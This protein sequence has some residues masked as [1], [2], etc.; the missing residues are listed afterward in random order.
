[1][2]AQ[3]VRLINTFVETGRVF[4]HLHNGKTALRIMSA[5]EIKQADIILGKNGWN[6]Y[7]EYLV[8][9]FNEHY[10]NQRITRIEPTPR[11]ERFWLLHF[12]RSINPLPDNE[13]E[14]YQN[15]LHENSF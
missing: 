6:A 15:L 5:R 9:L 4:F 8:D 12:S 1:M 3:D 10:A 14:E 13:E 11:E 7:V 2:K